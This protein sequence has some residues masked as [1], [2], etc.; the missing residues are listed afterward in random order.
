MRV[1]FQETSPDM[2]ISPRLAWRRA[3]DPAGTMRKIIRLGEGKA[4]TKGTSWGDYSGSVIDGD[5]LVDLWTVQSITDAGELSQN[6][7]MMEGQVDQAPEQF[8]PAMEIIL[9]KAKA[10]LAELESSSN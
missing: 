1:G 3:E 6:I 4:A 9:K 5:N 10:R 8:R 7:A 2:F